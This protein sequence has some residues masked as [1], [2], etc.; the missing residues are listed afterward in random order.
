VQSIF[1]READLDIKQTSRPE[2]QQQIQ[3]A[4]YAKSLPRTNAERH[5]LNGG[6]FSV[7]RKTFAGHID[8]Y[9][10]PR[11]VAQIIK[12]S[13]ALMS[14][15]A[16]SASAKSRQSFL[17][18][19]MVRTTRALAV[20]Y[21]KLF[22]PREVPRD[23]PSSNVTPISDVGNKYFVGQAAHIELSLCYGFSCRGG[24]HR[25]AILSRCNKLSVH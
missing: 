13:R 6:F 23:Q 12:M 9:L 5:P 11:L 7:I 2:A 20:Q 4:G 3:A 21:P 18:V 14:A 22:E 25:P 15:C 8:N 1:K 24:H 17:L 19:E 16:T 10:L